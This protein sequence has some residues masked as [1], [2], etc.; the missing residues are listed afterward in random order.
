MYCS[1]HE[2]KPAKGACVVCGRLFCED[3]LVRVDDK[4]YCKEHAADLIK[5]YG[6]TGKERAEQG[7]REA[8]Y[9][10]NYQSEAPHFHQNIYVNSGYP[11]YHPKSRIIALLL[12]LFFG[13]AGFH[14]FYVGKIGTGILYLLTG[15]FFGIGYIVDII[16]IAFGSFRDANGQLLE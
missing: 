16:T 1:T 13:V 11:H 4:F 3:C 6:G 10:P 2:Q 5:G 7:Y 15:G 8:R 12:C 14:R 9:E